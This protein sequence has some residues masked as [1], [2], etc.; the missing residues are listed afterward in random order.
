MTDRATPE[1]LFA[2][3]DRLSIAHATITH[4]PVFTVEEAKALRGKIEGGHTRRICS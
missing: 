2:E 3:L 4:P 1:Q